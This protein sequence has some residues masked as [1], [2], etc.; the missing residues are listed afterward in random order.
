MSSRI[1]HS[2]RGEQPDLGEA[3]PP[4]HQ[5]VVSPGMPEPVTADIAAPPSAATSQPVRPS[6]W[7]RLTRVV[8]T[9]IVMAALVG[10]G[11][12]GHHYGWKIPSFSRLSGGAVEGRS[13]WCEEHSVPESICIACNAKLMPKGKLHGWCEK[14]G[15]AECVLDHPEI[16]QLANPRV[17]QDDLDRAARALALKPRTTNDRACK[18]HL[19]RIQFADEEAIKKAGIDIR[20]ADRAPIVEAIAANG[21]IRFD[22]TRVSRL[23]ARAP[24]TVWR[25]EK[26]VGDRVREGDVLALIDSAD[27]NRAKADL[28]EAV[29]ELDLSKTTYNRLAQVAGPAIAKRRLQEAEAD[30]IKAEAAVRRAIQIL[31]NLNLHI[32][33]DDIREKSPPEL[34]DYVQ[35]LGLPGN[36]VAELE[37]GR[38]SGGLI[39]VMAPRDGDVVDVDAVANEVVD[40]TR[41]LF[42]I[43]D[44][45]SM[46]LMLNVPAEDAKY[47]RLGQKV[48]F[49]PDGYMEDYTGSVTWTST[50]MN[51]ETRMVEVRAELPNDDRRLLNET[52]GAG[53]I[54]LREEAEAIVIPTE[55]VH[56]EGCCFVTFV[57]DKDFLK[58]G[59]YKV[60]HTRMVRPGVANGDLTEMIAGVLPGEV[61]VTKGSGVLRAELL[62]GNLGAG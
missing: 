9:A 49:R 59:A 57:R 25:V 43:V 19:R 42:T 32:T 30:W 10:I 41:P 8:P 56:W 2:P 37:A 24:G 62:K 29:A 13:D 14:H 55:A 18:L 28:L 11:L 20:L 51:H 22:P 21:E 12:W 4:S 48:V 3:A 39:P 35:L 45:T 38:V 7:A 33:A 52:F 47:I 61:V 44:T 31:G 46:W 23:A 17:S 40:T 34:S 58:K 5:T 16:A 60:F 54:V 36:L 6:A 27:V 1:P 53:R 26:K 50:E 15:V